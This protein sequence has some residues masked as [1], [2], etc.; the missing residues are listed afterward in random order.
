MRILGS[1]F[2]DHI[3]TH[4]SLQSAMPPRHRLDPACCRQ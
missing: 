3:L 1:V 2:I 4:Y